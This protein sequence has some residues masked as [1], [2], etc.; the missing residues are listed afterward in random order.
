M[1]EGK[2]TVQRAEMQE[3]RP[4]LIQRYAPPT[5][6]VL[7]LSLILNPCRNQGNPGLRHQQSSLMLTAIRSSELDLT[8]N[9]GTGLHR[10]VPTAWVV[11]IVIGRAA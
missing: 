3:T 1:N 10:P 8:S 11:D 2:T 7:V 9:H 6:T 4:L 5:A